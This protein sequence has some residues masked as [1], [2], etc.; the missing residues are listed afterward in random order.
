MA[1][2]MRTLSQKPELHVLQEVNDEVAYDAESYWIRLLDQV[3]TVD[4]INTSDMAHG[5]PKGHHTHSAEVRA[6]MSDGIRRAYQLN[7]WNKSRVNHNSDILNRFSV[8]ELTEIREA[9]GTMRQIATRYG[10]SLTSVHRIKSGK[11]SH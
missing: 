9:T 2:W 4:L 10:I 5:Y 8:D 7:Q 11:L 6:R 1:E 3:P